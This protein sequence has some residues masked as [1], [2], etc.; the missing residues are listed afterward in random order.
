VLL[1]WAAILPP[2]SQ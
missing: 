2:E 1:A